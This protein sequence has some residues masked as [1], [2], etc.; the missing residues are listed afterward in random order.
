MRRQARDGTW[1]V[2]SQNHVTAPTPFS[3][4]SSATILHSITNNSEAR[5]PRATFGAP[6]NM[7][8]K[9]AA[10]ASA[11]QAQHSSTHSHS[12]ETSLDASL[13][14]SQVMDL[15]TMQASMDKHKLQVR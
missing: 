1:M 9:K 4:S 8:P 6:F 7:A 15:Q 14:M 13:D 5:I 3:I 11:S 2:Q 10:K 12:D